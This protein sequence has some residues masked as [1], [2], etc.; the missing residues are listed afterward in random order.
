MWF[1]GGSYVE[2]PIITIISFFLINAI[3]G[4]G[5]DWATIKLD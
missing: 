5:R 4:I 1:D 3:K 2:P